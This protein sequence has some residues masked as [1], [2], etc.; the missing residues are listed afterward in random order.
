VFAK[1]QPFFIN[2]NIRKIYILLKSAT[3]KVFIVIFLFSG[4]SRTGKRCAHIL[5]YF[6]GHPTPHL[7]DGDPYPAPGRPNDA[8][9][10]MP[11]TSYF[12]SVDIVRYD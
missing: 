11:P 1:R 6:L 10:A 4:S 8:A 7:L 12:T 2:V 3:E 9:P 5:S